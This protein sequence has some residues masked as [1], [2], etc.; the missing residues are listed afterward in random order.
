[1]N[2]SA[3]PLSD[4]QA[5]WKMDSVALGKFVLPAF[6]A[7]PKKL[8]SYTCAVLCTPE[9]FNICSIGL[10]SDQIG[11]MAALTSS[12]IAIGEA[13]V[14]SISPQPNANLD[15]LT[16][17]SGDLTTVCI[18]VPHVVG[19]L[20]LLVSARAAPLGAILMV[21]RSTADRVREL[22]PVVGG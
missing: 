20:L 17:Q 18:K 21:A 9:G 11:K 14:N 16:L 8:P 2:A 15:A 6:E 19:Y 7:L 3:G 12:L 22:L 1:M 13:S 10:S 5:E 4:H